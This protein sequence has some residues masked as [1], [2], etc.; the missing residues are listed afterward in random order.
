MRPPASRSK[1][2]I[3]LSLQATARQKSFGLKAKDVTYGF[4]KSLNFFKSNTL[5]TFPAVRSH[6]LTSP[7]W[8][9]EAANQ[10]SGDISTLATP[11]EWPL[12]VAIAPFYL[13]SQIFTL[14]S[15]DPEMI[16]SW[17]DAVFPVLTHQQCVKWPQRVVTNFWVSWFQTTIVPPNVPV[18]TF[19]S[20]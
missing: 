3:I 6:T 15:A 4:S 11:F 9:P 12:W 20:S 5:K 1:Y 13:K 17:F 14:V 10:E 16:N 18:N 19:S 7:A 2:Q 8:S